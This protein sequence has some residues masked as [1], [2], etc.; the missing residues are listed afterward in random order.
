LREERRRLEDL[1]Q[2]IDSLRAID[3]ETY[4]RRKAP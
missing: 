4:Q 2:K 1:Q 3:R